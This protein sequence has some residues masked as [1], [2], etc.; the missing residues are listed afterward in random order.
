GF[1]TTRFRVNASGRSNG[2]ASATFLIDN[3]VFSGCGPADP[4]DVL[5]PPTL[6]KGFSPAV[7]G[8]GH[9]ATLSFTLS[10]PNPTDALTGASFDDALPS[11]VA[12]GSPATASPTWRGPPIWPPTAGDSQLTFCAGTIPA[13]A[14]GTVSG[15]VTASTVGVSNNISGFIFASEP[16]GNNG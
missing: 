4:A 8:V 7:I 13:N 11:G 15:D 12:V 5:D 14:S 9:T 1:S 10:N 16:R 2:N 6:T 3:I